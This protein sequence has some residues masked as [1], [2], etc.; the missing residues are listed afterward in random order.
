MQIKC[1]ELYYIIVFIYVNKDLVST[2]SYNCTAYNVA[3]YT[4]SLLFYI[5]QNDYDT[6][7]L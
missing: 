3:I 4:H 6:V 2:D 7:H 5:F 1:N